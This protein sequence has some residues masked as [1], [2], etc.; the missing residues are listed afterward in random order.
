[1]ICAISKKKK[2]CISGII[3]QTFT[4]YSITG[5]IMFDNDLGDIIDE[6]GNNTMVWEEK[7]DCG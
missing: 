1:M 2:L 4:L 7:I 3:K 5:E 6:N